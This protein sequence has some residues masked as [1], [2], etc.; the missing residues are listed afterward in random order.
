MDDLA[1]Y[2]LKAPRDTVIFRE[3]DAGDVMFFIHAGRVRIERTIE[4]K[5]DVM[6]ILEKGD[7]FGEMSLLDH[8]PRTATAVV[9]EDAELL[10][11]DAANFQ[12]LVFG[13]IEIAIRMIRKYSARLRDAND[14]L[15]SLL[16]D[17]SQMD[18][19]IAEILQSVKAPIRPAETESQELALLTGEGPEAVSHSIR[20]ECVLIGRQDPVTNL[21]PDIDLTSSDRERGTS[22]RHARL[23]RMDGQFLLFEEPGVPNGTFVNGQRITPGQPVLIRN[24]DRVS[25][26][27]VPFTFRTKG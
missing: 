27:K 19:E 9:E 22:R 8:V 7:F 17:R 24:G 4:T 3:G 18:Q 12:K 1:R 15:A 25:F 13:N 2:A 14:K 11:V 26:G 16:K 5:T 23:K 10:K 20:K 21:S 6:A